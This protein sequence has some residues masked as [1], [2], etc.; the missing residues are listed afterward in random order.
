MIYVGA[1][2]V[3]YVTCKTNRVLGFFRRNV[4]ECPKELREIAYISIVRSIRVLECASA[5]KGPHLKQETLRIDQV[6]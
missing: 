2:Q 4:E 1:L 5:G 6:Q 3:E